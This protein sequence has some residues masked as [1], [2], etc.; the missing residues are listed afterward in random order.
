MSKPV[1]ISNEPGNQTAF[2]ELNLP[3][4]QKTSKILATFDSQFKLA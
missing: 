3:H 4:C 2:E 1:I